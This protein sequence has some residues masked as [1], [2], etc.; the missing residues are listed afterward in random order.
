[1]GGGFELVGWLIGFWLL[2]WLVGW[3]VDRLI[4]WFSP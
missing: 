2:G 4:S 3:W 1:M